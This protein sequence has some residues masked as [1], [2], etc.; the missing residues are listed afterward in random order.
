MENIGI[1]ESGEMME[2]ELRICGMNCKIEKVKNYARDYT[3][4]GT[5]CGN[6]SIIKLDNDLKLEV[7]QKT[8]LHEI[9]ECINYQF[10][11]DLEHNKI[12]TIESALFW[13]LRDN[14]WLLE[15]LLKEE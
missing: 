12:S 7:E 14:K 6:D 2:N 3:F 13:I 1:I 8:L 5:F 10:E 15:Y 4:L 9:I 11:L